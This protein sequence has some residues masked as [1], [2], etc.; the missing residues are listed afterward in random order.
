MAD[1][2]HGLIIQAFDAVIKREI[3]EADE[4]RAEIKQKGTYWAGDEIW[5]LRRQVVA[6]RKRVAE[7]E[8][9]DR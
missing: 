3:V 1:V 8:D 5:K 9:G 2:L 7:H 4:V 6:L